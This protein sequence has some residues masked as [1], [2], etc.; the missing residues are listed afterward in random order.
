M[1][2]SI[3]TGRAAKL[4]AY[5]AMGVGTFTFAA[6]AA[7]ADVIYTDLSGSELVFAST[8]PV[9][10]DMDGDLAADF[11]LELGT[12][13]PNLS[14]TNSWLLNLRAASGAPG[15]NAV[16]A[17]SFLSGPSTAGLSNIAFGGSI[18]GRDFNSFGYLQQAY[19]S[20]RPGTTYGSWSSPTTGYAG[21]RFEDGTGETRFGWIQMSV[22]G[23][24][25]NGD[26]SDVQV[27]VRGFAF[28][29]DEAITAGQTTSA[30][31][32][33]SAL[34]LLALG[35]IGVMARRRKASANS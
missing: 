23:S 19:T 21:V 9:S 31:P 18:S 15:A 33:P 16:V 13:G 28:A 32:E 1:I 12:F 10:I 4:A 29:R 6:S 11:R 14:S 7:N 30:V 20:F 5:G 3:K 26:F 22:E 35:G 17:S 24:V 25:A 27:T 34:A 2:Q 8:S